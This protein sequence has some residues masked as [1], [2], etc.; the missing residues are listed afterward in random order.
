MEDDHEELVGNIE[1]EVG[2][3]GEDFAGPSRNWRAK[4]IK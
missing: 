2:G 4:R 3:I 1:V